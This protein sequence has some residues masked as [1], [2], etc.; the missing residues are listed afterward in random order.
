MA[1]TVNGRY[2]NYAS[3][4]VNLLGIN[5]APYVKAI[6]YS[7]KEEFTPVKVIGTKKAV[8]FTQ[9]DQSNEGSITLMIE[10]LENLQRVLPPGTTIMDIPT[11]PISVG[12]VDEVGLQISHTLKAK[13]MKN[14]REAEAGNN[15][16]LTQQIELF[17]FDIN[18]NA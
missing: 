6:N 7:T 8:G 17:V 1:I 16:A 3:V 11:F 5:A 12:Y 10:F 4:R 13:F 15:D 14:G 2:K 9:G 18:W